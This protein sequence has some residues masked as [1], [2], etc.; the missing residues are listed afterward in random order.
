MAKVEAA[1]TQG[2]GGSGE[3]WHNASKNGAS[4]IP[5]GSAGGPSGAVEPKRPDVNEES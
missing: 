4:H 2:T 5:G 1:G 3:R